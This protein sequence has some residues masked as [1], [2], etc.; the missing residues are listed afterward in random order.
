LQATNV[1]HPLEPLIPHLESYPRGAFSFADPQSPAKLWA[2][3][4]D[5]TMSDGEEHWED[6]QE[7][8]EEEE[9]DDG[10]FPSPPPPSFL[11]PSSIPLTALGQVKVMIPGRGYTTLAVRARGQIPDV[12]CGRPLQ[13]SLGA[14]H[15]AALSTIHPR[16]VW[17]GRRRRCARRPRSGRL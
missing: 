3:P 1:F 4:V 8:E 10:T 17:I 14:D 12:G 9:D 7:S 13:L 15:A 16:G 6:E 11:D 2:T 5:A